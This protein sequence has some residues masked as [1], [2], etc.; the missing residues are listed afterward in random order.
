MGPVSQNE[1]APRK[2]AP[3]ERH[4]RP[5]VEFVAIK[6]AGGGRVVFF[7]HPGKILPGGENFK[8]CS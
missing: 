1:I 7:A 4:V 3:G 6:S 8:M 2:I 5:A